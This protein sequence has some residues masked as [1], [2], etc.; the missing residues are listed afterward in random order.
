MNSAFVAGLAGQPKTLP[1]VC[2]TGNCTFIDETQHSYTTI[3][4]DSYC[5]DVTYLLEQHGPTTWSTTGNYA[6]DPDSTDGNGA[7]ETIYKLP[8]G[9]EDTTGVFD[10]LNY[11]LESFPTFRHKERWSPAVSIS[12]FEPTGLL[13]SAQEEL[14]SNASAIT[15]AFVI[16]RN[17]PC[18]IDGLGTYELDDVQPLAA[19]NTSQCAA[20]QTHNVTSFPGSW[21][22]NAAV[23]YLYPS[24]RQYS[25]NVTNG[26]LDER[27]IGDAVPMQKGHLGGLGDLSTSYFTFLDPCLID[28]SIYTAS[29]YSAAPDLITVSFP[30]AS[31][32]YNVTVPKACLYV[33]PDD[34][35]EALADSISAVLNQPEDG[36]CV[37]ASNYSDILCDNRWWLSDLYNERN[38]SLASTSEFMQNIA[39]SLTVQLRIIGTDIDGQPAFISGTAF[40]TEVCTRFVWEWLLFPVILTTLVA[41]LLIAVSTVPSIGWE[42]P[43]KMSS[44]PLLFYGLKYESTPNTESLK[45]VLD[46]DELRKIAR[47]VSVKFAQTDDGWG[48]QKLE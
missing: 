3:A 34:W 16:P 31:T 4:F 8:G 47:S 46:E 37:V 27:L 43:W 28:K 17:S 6:S 21:C 25:G 9:W 36:E 24:L 45:E 35:D 23:C 20:I 1:F 39:D 22:L 2:T 5:S 14:I 18:D 33:L 44:L 13:L 10:F 41:L 29:N 11:S 26:E 7:G 19:V 30:D 15:Q 38:S 32:D 12:E 48:F 42:V 40:H